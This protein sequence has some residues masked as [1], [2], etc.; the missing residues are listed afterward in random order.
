[1]FGGPGYGEAVPF[2]FAIH[3]RHSSGADGFGDGVAGKALSKKR[4][5]GWLCECISHA[6]GQAGRAFPTVVHAHS[7]RGMAVSTALFNGVSVE[8]ICTAVVI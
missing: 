4:L 7:T 2:T 1:M 5:T 3:V 8:D 6:Y